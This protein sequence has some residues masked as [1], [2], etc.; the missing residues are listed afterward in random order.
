MMNSCSPE[1]CAAY[2]AV[3]GLVAE[4]VCACVAEAEVAA[5]QD[6][7]VPQVDHAHHALRTAV[8]DVVVHV[9]VGLVQRLHSLVLQ[10]VDLLQFRMYD[11]ILLDLKIKG[12]TSGIL[13]TRLGL[14][15]LT[16]CHPV[17]NT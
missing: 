15:T 13:L 4:A 12:G 5:R 11:D 3:V 16:L 6:D 10:A 9:R 1:G 17:Y 2:G 7:G 8:V 14:F